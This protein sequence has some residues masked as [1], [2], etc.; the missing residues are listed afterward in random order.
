MHGV[1]CCCMGAG[2]SSSL[3]PPFP[4]AHP[5]PPAFAE[6][7]SEEFMRLTGVFVGP[8][9]LDQKAWS[10][11]PKK[12]QVLATRQVARKDQIALQR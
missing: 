6:R 5:I 4:H 10:K 7:V 3:C 1:A 12:L 11:L 2:T 8:E 9:G